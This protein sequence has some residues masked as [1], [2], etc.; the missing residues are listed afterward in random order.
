MILGRGLIRRRCRGGVMTAAP[1]V[2]E[3]AAPANQTRPSALR[4]VACRGLTHGKAPQSG[5]PWRL[6]SSAKTQGR[7][8]AGQLSPPPCPHSC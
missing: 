2:T 8:E 1:G 5:D 7:E 3:A 4:T 6:E